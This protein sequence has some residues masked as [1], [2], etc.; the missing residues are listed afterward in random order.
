M[1]KKLQNVQNIWPR[2]RGGVFILNC[3]SLQP[4]EGPAKRASIGVY[5]PVFA[6]FFFTVVFPVFI[7]VVIISLIIFFPPFLYLLDSYQADGPNHFVDWT[8]LDFDQALSGLSSNTP[9]Q[10]RKKANVNNA[11]Y[12]EWDPLRC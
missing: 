12:T 1:C 2:I 3:I 7:M 5:V 9:R 10:Q 4:G 11:A 6:I 8:G